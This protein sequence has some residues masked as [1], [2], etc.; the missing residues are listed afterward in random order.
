MPVLQVSAY[1][2]VG[3]PLGMLSRLFLGSHSSWQ[4]LSDANIGSNQRPSV[5]CLLLMGTRD[6]FTS[7]STVEQLVQQQWDLHDR[8]K[9]AAK[10]AGKAVPHTLCKAFQLQVLKG[11]DH[12][13][14]DQW[15]RVASIAVS[16]ATNL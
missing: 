10:T 5:P 7:L 2:S 9:D 4:A 12:F 3:F 1:V 11:C 13:F 8:L 14:F 15:E 6:Q 16:W